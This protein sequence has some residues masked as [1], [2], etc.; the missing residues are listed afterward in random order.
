MELTATRPAWVPSTHHGFDSSPPI[1][2]DLYPLEGSKGGATLQQNP[3]PQY[4]SYQPDSHLI[5]IKS[6]FP[7][8]FFPDELHVESGKLT[9]VN[10]NFFFSDDVHTILIHSIKDIC[11]E[12]SVFFSTFK[13]MPDGFPADRL[14]VP[15]LKKHEAAAAYKI[16]QQ[17]MLDRI[18]HA[19]YLAT[20]YQS[21]P[22]AL[23]KTNNPQVSKYL[24]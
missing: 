4:S 9:I 21:D 16:V 7:F 11:V 8:D 17:L 20:M 1:Y 22:K 12:S 18:E 24:Q 3:N 19:S 6:V 14:K 2:Y 10:K 23:W 5:R 15:F 13:I